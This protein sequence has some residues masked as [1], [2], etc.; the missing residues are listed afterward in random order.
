MTQTQAADRAGVS[1]PFWSRLERGLVTA[2]TLETLAACASAVDVQL[3]AFIEARPGADLP[4]D[5]EHVRRQE[6]VVTLAAKGGWR[7]RPE[8]PID[9]GAPRSRNIDVLLDRPNVHDTAEIAVVEIEDLLTDVGDAFR[10]LGDKVAAIER[11]QASKSRLQGSPRIAGLLVLRA[12]RRNREIVRR[13]SGVF[14]TRFPAASTAWLRALSIADEPMP[15][16]D[17]FL[18]SSVRGDRLFAARLGV[19]GPAGNDGRG[20]G[21]RG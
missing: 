16:R 20:G 9:P 7:A 17:G 13:L 8:R 4:R 11:E 3:A 14:R 12:T 15:S 2:V 1:Q 19:E 6:L 21:D 18:W 5:I 10:G